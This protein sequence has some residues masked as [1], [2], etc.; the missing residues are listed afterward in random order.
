[1]P[2]FKRAE[3]FFFREQ[4]YFNLAVCRFM[5]FSYIL[6]LHVRI[7]SNWAKFT[8]FPAIFYNP[9]GVFS[10]VKDLGVTVA[11]Y[12]NLY[13]VSIAF[14][15][16]AAIGFLGRISFIVSFF[17]FGFLCQQDLR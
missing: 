12:E 4:T 2:M 10:F 7:M 13:W 16:F 5:F 14:C 6:F 8:E 15:F 1:M 11:F 3:Y 9:Y 17:C